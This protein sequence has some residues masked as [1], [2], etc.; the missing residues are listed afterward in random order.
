MLYIIH[1]DRSLIIVL[2][3]CFSLVA[4]SQQDFSKHIS[5]NAYYGFIFAH[6][7]DV[8]NTAGS[9][10]FGLS[11]ELSKLKF[12]S[13]SYNTARCY[14]KTG[15]NFIYFNYDNAILGHSLTCAYFIEP[16]FLLSKLI[17]FA[18]RG[19]LGLSYLTNPHHSVHNPGNNSYS[20]TISVFLQ[21]GLSIQYRITSKTALLFSASYLHVSNG[22]L[23]IPNRGI[24]WPAASLGLSYRM[25][26][27]EFQRQKYSPAK[28]FNAHNKVEFG[29]Y[30]SVKTLEDHEGKV[31]PVP[32][33]CLSYYRRIN[34]LHSVGIIADV[35]EDQSLAAQQKKRNE[36]TH[37]VFPSLAIGHEYLLGKINFWQQIG[38]YVVAPDE[39][40][41]NW[42]HRWGLSYNLTKQLNI[43]VG[44]KAHAHVAHFA[45]LRFAYN[46]IY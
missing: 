12:D 8:E 11:L 13:A 40:F 5:A 33:F 45:D 32:G 36:S 19:S 2:V 37:S 38:Y 25:N 29:V 39:R 43:G 23:K 17:M 16:S 22:G 18:P 15:I 20:L 6:N 26:S 4:K 24:N 28:R 21:L 7:K 14:P 30:S 27:A 44:I 46:L 34:N 3:L 35:H 31:F 1:L 9:K 41:I 10:P 42:Y